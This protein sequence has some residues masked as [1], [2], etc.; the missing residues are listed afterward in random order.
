MNRK[1]KVLMVCLT[2]FLVFGSTAAIHKPATPEDAHK[3][4]LMDYS[5]ALQWYTRQARIYEIHYQAA[6]PEIQAKW[7]AEIDPVFYDAKD[8]LDVWGRAVKSGT[9]DPDA[10]ACF[11][12]QYTKLELMG[13]SFLEDR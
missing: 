8:A 5:D 7:K 3:M 2:L 13:L 9:L 11:E 6:T 4:A 1:S 12:E 10:E